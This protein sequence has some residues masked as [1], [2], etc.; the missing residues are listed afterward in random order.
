MHP[1]PLTPTRWVDYHSPEWELLASTG[2]I[3][4]Y[5]IAGRALMVKEAGR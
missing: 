1:G 2:W 3:T 5:V 4:A